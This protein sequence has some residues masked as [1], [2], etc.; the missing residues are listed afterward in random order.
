MAAL[1]IFLYVAAM[2]MALHHIDN[3][4]GDGP[5][6][7]KWRVAATVGWPVFWPPLYLWA[8]LTSI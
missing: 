2:P 6:L 1:A 4:I 8:A 7:L 5:R 3:V